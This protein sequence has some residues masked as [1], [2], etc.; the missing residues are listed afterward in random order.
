M[1]HIIYV[2]TNDTIVLLS[3]T[4]GT[5]LNNLTNKAMLRDEDIDAEAIDIHSELLDTDFD[6]VGWEPES[7]DDSNPDNDEFGYYQ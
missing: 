1:E 2:P 7:I 4:V 6:E 3:N 5:T